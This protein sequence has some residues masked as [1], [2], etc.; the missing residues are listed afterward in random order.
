MYSLVF[1]FFE[2]SVKI[3]VFALKKKNYQYDRGR[4]NSDLFAI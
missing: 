3:I 4:V 2:G 1:H